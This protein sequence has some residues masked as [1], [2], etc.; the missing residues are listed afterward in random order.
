MRHRPDN[1]NLILKHVSNPLHKAHRHGGIK[2][3]AHG[4]DKR[5]QRRRERH[6]E[7]VW[8]RPGDEG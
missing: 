5:T 4:G 1:P 3:G 2:G 6:Q 8:R 7:K